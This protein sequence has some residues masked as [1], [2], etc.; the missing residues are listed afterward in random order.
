MRGPFS[1][2]EEYMAQTKSL[3]K[4]MLAGTVIVMGTTS[5]FAL[6]G[7]D[8]AKGESVFKKC[9]SCHMVGPEAQNKVG[10]QLNELFG[11]TAG[12]AADY[13]YGDDL[14]AAGEAGLVWNDDEVYA[15]LEDPRAYLR[16]KL[17]D[18]KAKSK[19]AF[20]LK[21]EDERK[22]VIAYLKTFSTAPAAEEGEAEPAA[23]EETTT[24]N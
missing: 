15:Y 20:K 11:R 3:L 14:I 1:Q 8:A 21:K 23:Q 10:P 22:D 2:P 13:K 5:A 18:K 12:T 16:E 4:T 9:A 7:G 17:D 6:D 24:T 19:M